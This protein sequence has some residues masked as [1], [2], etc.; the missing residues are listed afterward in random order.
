ML[1]P[2]AIGHKRVDISS[3]LSKKNKKTKQE[4]KMKQS[5]AHQM[6]QP[7]ATMLTASFDSVKLLFLRYMCDASG[8]KNFSQHL[9]YYLSSCSQLDALIFVC[10]MLTFLNLRQF[11]NFLPVPNYL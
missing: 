5:E 3:S 8:E 7:F 1:Q 2:S 11:P 4:R 10:T 6:R 9:P